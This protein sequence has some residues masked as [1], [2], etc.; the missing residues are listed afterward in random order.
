[1]KFYYKQYKKYG[2]RKTK[3]NYDW[4]KRRNKRMGY[5]NALII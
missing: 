2:G 1:M 3:K 5:D 4:L